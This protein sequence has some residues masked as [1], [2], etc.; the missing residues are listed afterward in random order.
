[1][2]ALFIK[3]DTTNIPFKKNA[4]V[5]LY[6]NKNKKKQSD[7][8]ISDRIGLIRSIKNWIG[9]SILFII[10]SASTFAVFFIFYFIF[11]DALPF[12]QIEGF[13]EFLPQHDGIHLASRMNLE[14]YLFLLGV[15]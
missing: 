9:K 2:I 13:K 3:F 1:M 12:F 8:V 6:V 5:R 4:F 7:L 15:L 10:T 14:R 11:K